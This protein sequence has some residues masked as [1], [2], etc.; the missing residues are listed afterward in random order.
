MARKLR[1]HPCAQETA[2]GQQQQP[3]H[4]FA[5]DSTEASLGPRQLSAVSSGVQACAWSIA[6]LAPGQPGNAT[7]HRH[8]AATTNVGPS[9]A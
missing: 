9:S 4:A 2:T 5:V 8:K 3:T 1:Q 6:P 7:A